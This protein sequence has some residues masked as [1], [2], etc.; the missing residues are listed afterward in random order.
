MSVKDLTDYQRARITFER[1]I[2]YRP[3]DEAVTMAGD[4]KA[5]ALL[6]VDIPR[7]YG[8]ALP[9]GVYS[10]HVPSVQD[11]MKGFASSTLKEYIVIRGEH[12]VGWICPLDKDLG[13][14]RLW[15][16]RTHLEEMKG[17]ICESFDEF[18]L[19]TGRLNVLRGSLV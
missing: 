18:D 7:K 17:W 5:A 15:F 1:L 19:V 10:F 14:K 11:P 16:L 2:G 12:I 4:I 3:H 6:V 8:L 13:R 9:P